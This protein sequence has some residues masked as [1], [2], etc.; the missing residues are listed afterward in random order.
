MEAVEKGRGCAAGL[1]TGSVTCKYSSI[2]RLSAQELPT[3]PLGSHAVHATRCILALLEFIVHTHSQYFPEKAQVWQVLQQST[4]L[5]IQRMPWGKEKVFFALKAFC[6]RQFSIMANT[7]SNMDLKDVQNLPI[8]KGYP[9]SKF[10]LSS[11]I[12]HRHSLSQKIIHLI[13]FS[14][15]SP[16]MPFPFPFYKPLSFSC[17]KLVIPTVIYSSCMWQKKSPHHRVLESREQTK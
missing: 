15:V 9:N 10:A 2:N 4:V 16:S 11:S 12:N 3:A 5:L 7:E 17:N 6:L 14:G 1:Q 13:S 8:C